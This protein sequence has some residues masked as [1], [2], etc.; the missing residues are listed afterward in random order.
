[1]K[2]IGV[3][4]WFN[5]S[6]SWLA[7]TIAS[8]ARVC[9]HIVAVDG[10]YAL[11]PHELAASPIQ[12]A[13][14]ILETAE[15]AGVACTLHRPVEPFYG[16]EIEKRNLLMRLAMVHAEP[17]RD[18][19]IVLD[20]DEY[21]VDHAVDFRDQLERTDRLVATYALQ[22]YMDPDRPEM[23]LNVA[24]MRSLPNVWQ[25]PIRSIYRALPG[26]SYRGTHYAIGAEI[27]GRTTTWL[28]GHP[29]QVPELDLTAFLRVRH[30]NP[31]R[32]MLRREQAAGYYR[33]R[34]EMRIEQPPRPGPHP[35]IGAN[36]DRRD[37]RDHGRD[38]DEWDRVTAAGD[39]AGAP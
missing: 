12:E 30:R 36:D 4:S 17:M 14:T 34:D 23:P 8:F 35:P 32:P 1:M 24:R 19:L 22:E 15:G 28:W 31:L 9:D 26:L 3:I 27:D 37:H 39:T 13:Q 21:I 33:A 18:W 25:V 38:L 6:P 16:N 29:D 11:F 20:G 7:A 5:E 10:R 2:V